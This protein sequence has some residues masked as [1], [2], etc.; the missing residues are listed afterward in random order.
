MRQALG[1]QFS[2]RALC[3]VPS[4]I[5]ATT[6]RKGRRED[7]GRVLV[8]NVY[9]CV[10]ESHHREPA[11]DGFSHVPQMTC[12]LACG[13]NCPQPVSC[14]FKED[15]EQKSRRFDR[16]VRFIRKALDR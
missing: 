5:P 1:A 13:L 16:I 7:G 4:S 10:V 14:H 2:D 9:G 11:S 12:A 6:K 3:G 8:S 15:K